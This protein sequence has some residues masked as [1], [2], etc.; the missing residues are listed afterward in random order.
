MGKYQVPAEKLKKVLEI[1]SRNL[2]QNKIP[3]TVV[4]AIALGLYG[5]PR[6]TSDIDLITEGRLWPGLDSIMEKLDPV[7]E[8]KC[9]K[10]N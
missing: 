6:F 2:T 1:I 9:L 3:F 4:G 7:F 10:W 8:L 5:F